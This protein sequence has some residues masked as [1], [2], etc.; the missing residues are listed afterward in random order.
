M[1]KPK[2]CPSTEPSKSVWD[3]NKIL[4]CYAEAYDST[5]TIEGGHKKFYDNLEKAYP[6]LDLSK[7]RIF[8]GLK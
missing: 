1:S 8:G 4:D 5:P 3:V 2:S 6:G 7:E